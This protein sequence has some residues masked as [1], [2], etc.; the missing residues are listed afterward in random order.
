M[1]KNKIIFGAVALYTVCLYGT[2]AMMSIGAG[3]VFLT[4]IFLRWKQL[5]SDFNLFRRKRKI[6]RRSDWEEKRIWNSDI[7]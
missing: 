4:W 5:R 1:T 3:L 6:I 7:P 2:M